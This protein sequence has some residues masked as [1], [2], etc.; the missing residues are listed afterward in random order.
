MFRKKI[1]R[2]SKKRIQTS[3]ASVPT[4]STVHSSMFFYVVRGA[5]IMPCALVLAQ[6]WRH[7]GMHSCLDR[8]CSFDFVQ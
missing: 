1:Q 4:D 2:T 8:D 7:S 6:V 5:P 3:Y